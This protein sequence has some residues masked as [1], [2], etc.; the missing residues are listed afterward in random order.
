MQKYAGDGHVVDRLPLYHDG[1]LDEQ[2]K[3]RV[4]AHLESCPDCQAELESL[5]KLSGVLN[6]ARV[7]APVQPAE[8]FAA[9]VRAELAGTRPQTGWQ[10]GLRTAWKAA[11]FVW[12]GTWL[13]IQAVSLAAALLATAGLGGLLDLGRLAGIFLWRSLPE[14]LSLFLVDDALGAIEWLAPAGQW[15]EFGARNL[16]LTLVMGL[17]LWGW[18]ASWWL[19]QKNEKQKRF[20]IE[21]EG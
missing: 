6:M 18:I 10:R 15:V 17:G 5:R 21:S 7:P 16:G 4:E 19:Y 2:Q 1:E 11:P 14:L 8:A 9:R 20:V 12:V 3:A 13:F